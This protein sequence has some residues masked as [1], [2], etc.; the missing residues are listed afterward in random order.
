MAMVKSSVGRRQ[1]RARGAHV[2]PP[3]A[4]GKRTERQ[5]VDSGSLFV[6]HD[7]ASIR[8]ESP[9]SR[10]QRVFDALHE[11]AR[12][13][14]SHSQNSLA[15]SLHDVHA[16]RCVQNSS[17]SVEMGLYEDGLSAYL[18]KQSH[19]AWVLG[20]G[21]GVLLWMSPLRHNRRHQSCMKRRGQAF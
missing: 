19:R 11:D 17:N 10:V 4:G 2:V 21:S 5:C 8:V 7:L 6:S 3:E 20:A 9:S 14:N 16:A 1:R 15:C 12:P 13:H 18:G